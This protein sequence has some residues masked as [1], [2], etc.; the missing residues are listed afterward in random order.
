MLLQCV[1]LY[2]SLTVSFTEVLHWEKPDIKTYDDCVTY[3]LLE[4]E[5]RNTSLHHVREECNKMFI[6]QMQTWKQNLKDQNVINYV[7]S[8]LR[9]IYSKMATN[10]KRKKRSLFNNVYFLRREIREPPYDKVWGCFLR[11]VRRLKHLYVS[12]FVIDYQ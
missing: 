12:N 8:L 3:E 4:A 2:I 11:G 7:N 1:I 9:G 6:T 10:R 5:A